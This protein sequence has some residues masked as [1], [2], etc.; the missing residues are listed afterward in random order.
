MAKA[1]SVLL[2]LEDAEQ[3]LSKYDA[4]LYRGKVLDVPY[5][6][7]VISMAK[8]LIADQDTTIRAMTGEFGDSCDS[9]GEG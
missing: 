3:K 6:R 5:V 1:E 4:V 8:E 7:R 2:A 9:C